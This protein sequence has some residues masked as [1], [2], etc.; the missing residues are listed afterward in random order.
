MTHGGSERREKRIFYYCKYFCFASWPPPVT[1]IFESG[2]P[3]NFNLTHRITHRIAL[4]KLQRI[5]G[6]K[7]SRIS[8]LVGPSSVLQRLKTAHRTI[9]VSCASFHGLP[10]VGHV[11]RRSFRAPGCV[12]ARYVH[13]SRLARRPP[14]ARRRRDVPLGRPLPGWAPSSCVR[15]GLRA[16]AGGNRHRWCHSLHPILS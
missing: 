14:D 16:S 13:S 8:G 7:S 10:A 3:L 9:R 5:W 12:C 2:Y 11:F 15:S 4:K 1:E 6:Q